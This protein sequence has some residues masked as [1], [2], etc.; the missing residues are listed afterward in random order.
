MRN[1][2]AVFLAGLLAG[3]A[4]SPISAGDA[5]PGKVIAFQLAPPHTATGEFVVTRDVGMMGA[6][7]KTRV[8]I[9]STLFAELTQGQTATAH[10]TP[11]EHIAGVENGGICGGGVAQASFV[12]VE[13]AT[14]Y[15]RIA[16]GQSGDLKIEPTAF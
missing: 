14:R 2:S 7:C 8:F 11:G 9:D 1:L 10:L 15:Y 12:I 13:G 4:T 3:C 16:G 6:A 5:T